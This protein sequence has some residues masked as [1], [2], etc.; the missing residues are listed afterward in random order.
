MKL[1]TAI[2]GGLLGLLGLLFI[3]AGLAYFLKFVP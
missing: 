3:F 1:A 2:A